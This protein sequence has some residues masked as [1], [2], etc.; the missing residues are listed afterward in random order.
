MTWL[1]CAFFFCTS[2]LPDMDATCKWGVRGELK[3]QEFVLWETFTLMTQI[4]FCVFVTVICVWGSSL[5]LIDTWSLCKRWCKCP[6]CEVGARS[7]RYLAYL[8]RRLCA[9]LHFQKLKFGPTAPNPS[10]PILATCPSGH[11]YLAGML[12]PYNWKEQYMVTNLAATGKIV[13]FLPRVSCDT[14]KLAGLFLSLPNGHNFI[15][16]FPSVTPVL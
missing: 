3:L 1:I 2:I 5:T 13:E 16:K 8:Q 10:S 11:S 14:L 12:L 9:S 7:P 4:Y 15:N 6:G